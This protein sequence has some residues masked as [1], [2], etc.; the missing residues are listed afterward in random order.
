M[1][2][3]ISY[4]WGILADGVMTILM[5]WPQGFLR[6]MNANLENGTSFAYGLANGAPLMFGW[7]LL[8]FWADRKPVQRKDILL[9]TLPVVFGYVLIKIHAIFSG[10][11]A[12]QDSILLFIHQAALMGMF[13]FS[14]LQNRDTDSKV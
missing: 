13:I 10:I 2:L 5:L 6:F 9:L 14:Y 8:L 11:G 1:L 12:W 3:R 7:T 4:W